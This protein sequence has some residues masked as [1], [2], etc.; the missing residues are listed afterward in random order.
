[1]YK[2]EEVQRGGGA[3]DR[4]DIK[5]ELFSLSLSLSLFGSSPIQ[6]FKLIKL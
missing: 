5:I 2:T 3:E 4:E 6:T 1:M